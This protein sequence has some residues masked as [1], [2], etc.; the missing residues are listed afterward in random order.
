M[1]LLF[2]SPKNKRYFLSKSQREF[3]TSDGKLDLTKA[4]PGKIIKTHIGVEYK[5]VKPSFLDLLMNLK[6]G[7]QVVLPKDAAAIVAHTGISTGAKVLDSG[8][9]SGWLTAFLANIV[10]PSGK[11]VSY[12]IRED[13][14]KLAKENIKSLGLKNVKLKVGD[15]TKG[16]S[17]KNLDLITLDILTPTKVPKIAKALKLGG[18]CVVYVPHANQEKRFVR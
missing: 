4:K 18:Y 9:G 17:E 16:F 7:P 5:C 15:I 8:T 6:R 3:H 14:H 2:I 1:K 10:G 13:H 12:E 11:V